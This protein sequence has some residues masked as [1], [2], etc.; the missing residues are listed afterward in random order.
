VEERLESAERVERSAEV[1]RRLK[2]DEA[3]ALMLKAEGLSYVEI[4]ERLGWTY[5]K[6]NRCI[7]EGRRRFM[8]L[9][10]ELE[11]GAECERLEPV[12]VALVAG[13]ASSEAL[14]DLRPHLR[15]C[16]ACR[17]T[18]RALHASRLR[19][20]TAWL[21]LGALVE[22]ARAIIE[23]FRP[24]KGSSEPAIELHPMERSEKLD[25]AFRR[26]HSSEAAVQPVAPSVAEAAGRWSGTRLNLRGWLEAALQRLQTSD[27]AMSVH[28]A[29][30]GGGGRVSA[31]AAL[32]GICVSG[33]GA[34][35]Y[36]VATALLPDPK[37]GVRVEAKPPPSK[38][39]K[40]KPSRTGSAASPPKSSSTPG[41]L[42]QS[43]P[44]PA[45]TRGKR[46]ASHQR[47][48]QK[49]ANEPDEF[50]F[51]KS[52]TA[53][54]STSSGSR[55]TSRTPTTQTADTSFESGA[56]SSGAG[57]GEFS[58]GTGGEFSP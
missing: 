10:A 8:K 13:E 9:Y 7:T 31:V 1:M 39:A 27:V 33:V 23:R 45:P 51:E 40:K 19:R 16:P 49:P 6:V 29:T 47:R 46:T 26:I 42:V 21:P 15:N 22:P 28:A 34:G 12:L 18:V 38:R 2:R 17:A 41:A 36:C 20:V 53:Q 30:S 25:E 32:I 44:T 48:E 24:P 57:G 4:G 11:A 3:K 52:T 56:A 35:T 43:S 37:P 54:A 14:L 58:D 50:S 55:S 5:T